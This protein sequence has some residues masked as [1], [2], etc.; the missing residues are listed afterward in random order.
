MVKFR[1][2][3][4]LATSLLMAGLTVGTAAAA[5]YPEPFVTSGASDAAVVYGASA[6][7]D[8]VQATN[9]QTDLATYVTATTTGSTVTGDSVLLAKS[10]DNLNV[11]NGI[12]VGGVTID[13]D[14]LSTLLADGT[15]TNDENTE[16]NY[17]QKITLGTEVDLSHFA[18]GDYADKAPTLGFKISSSTVILNYTL[19]FTTD[20]E[21]DVSGSDLVDIETTDITILGK[22]YYILNVDNVTNIKMTLMDAA[23]TATIQEGETATLSIDGVSY[24]VSISYV[25]QTGSTDKAKL[26]INGDLTNEL[27]E[28]SDPYKLGGGAYLGIK[29][30]VYNSKDTGISQ[31]EFSIGSG[32]LEIE[33]NQEI[34]LNDVDID[35][36]KGYIT[37]G[38]AASGREKIDKIILEW[39][40][41]DE[42]FLAPDTEL[43]LPGFQSVKFTMGDF[44]RPKPETV[45]VSYS[46][47]DVIELTVPVKSGEVTLPIL[48][49]NSTTGN[50]TL[51]GKDVDERLLTTTNATAIFFQ[52]HVD[53]NYHAYFVA[54]YNTTTDSESY[55]LRAKITES[56]AKNRTTIENLAYAE[57][58]AGRTAC[59]DKVAGDECNIGDVTLNIVEVHKNATERWAHFTGA[60]N[61]NFNTIFTKEGLKIYLPYEDVETN[62]DDAAKNWG[63]INLSYGIPGPA[64]NETLVTGRSPDSVYLYMD[65]EDKDDNIAGGTMF[66]MTLDTDSDKKA[67][68]TDA[69]TGQSELDQLTGAGDDTVS[70]VYSDMATKVEEI[71]V[72]D[73]G[74]AVITYSGQEAYAE[75]YL[76]ESSATISSGSAGAV[77]VKDSEVSSVST[78]NLVVVG[79]S[80]INSAAA[81][82]VG[83]AYCGEEWTTATGVGA[84]QY[85]VK[86][87]A[88]SGITS[89]LALLVAG[90]EAADTAAAATY[91]TTQKPDTS[92][93][94]IGPQ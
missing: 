82:L 27:T 93:E 21:S 66:N 24:V 53:N 47:D 39:I 38:T 12:D 69:D 71:F 85:L 91:L 42:V 19:D 52:E 16:Y 63:M 77:M 72:S 33:N 70:V 84:N 87:Y 8:A 67:H 10:S 18:D 92:S 36:L 51:I 94:V 1:K 31:V 44:V 68:M 29:N 83:G 55:L 61:V 3:T 6:S 9:I 13:D 75:V 7:L 15:Y 46:G 17:E 74:K 58:E 45:T 89:K 80:C 81:A 49:S 43:T 26:V 4:A 88:T 37:R 34:Q 57:G 78:K 2:V 50:F 25:T 56:D 11:N 79:G 32:K 28:S 60:T 35:G 30:I 22:T 65:E 48:Q 86:G 23:N 5:S 59:A 41:D 54:T 20:A 62:V 76:S 64:E 90:Y 14:D 40:N 73:R